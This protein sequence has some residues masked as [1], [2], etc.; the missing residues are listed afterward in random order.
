MKVAVCVGGLVYPDSESR[1]A[2]LRRKFPKY[3]FFFG[4]WKGREN[5]L[6]QK[7]GAWSFDEH[8]P[9]YHPYFDVNIPGMS[10]KIF[11]IRK[12]MKD[13]PGMPMIEKSWHQTKQI[14][15]HSHML[16]KLPPEY[17]MIVRTRFDINIADDRLDLEG[18]VKESYNERR[19]TG[20]TK[21]WFKKRPRIFRTK[22]SDRHDLWEQ[23]LMDLILMHPRE[24]FAKERMWDLHRRKELLASEFGWY[25]VLSEPH[26]DT[27]ENFMCK[28][29]EFDYAKRK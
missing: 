27:H 5:A 20:F 22:G 23:Y 6:S 24:L 2:A 10:K 21:S 14:L 15:M 19:A 13:N 17:D 9:E 12:K 25:Q 18:F 3:D 16:D 7:L 4:V 11:I 1:M 8:K 29:L 26:G 28:H